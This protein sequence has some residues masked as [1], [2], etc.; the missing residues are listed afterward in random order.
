MSL[1]PTLGQGYLALAQ[2][3]VDLGMTDSAYISTRRALE[4]G[5]RAATV[6]AFAL[7]RGN[8]LYRAANTTR[9][10]RD[11]QAAFWFLSLA[12]SLQGS[13]SSNFLLG[14]TA[15]AISQSAASDAPTTRECATSRLAEELLPLAREKITAGAVVAVDAARQY[16]AYLDQL[17][18][19]VAQQVAT[20][21]SGDSLRS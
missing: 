13:P 16:L 8:A 19:V 2:T 10:R 11:Y 14:A 17:E 4:R 1:D 21:C 18:P 9:E 3:Q 6:A 7:A 5:E 15:L 12:D 20:L